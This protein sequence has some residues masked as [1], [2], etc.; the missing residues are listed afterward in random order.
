MRRTATVT[1][2]AASTSG[3]VLI[4]KTEVPAFIPRDDM[5]DQLVRWAVI[6]SNDNAISKYGMPFKV[7]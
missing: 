4:S 1:Y 5:A 7:C 2:A 3:G 6:E